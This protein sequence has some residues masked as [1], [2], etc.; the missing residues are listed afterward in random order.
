MHRS[1]LSLS[2]LVHL[3]WT[4][5]MDGMIEAYDAVKGEGCKRV[6]AILDEI[7]TTGFPKL[8][9]YA[10]TVAGR[11]ISLLP[12]VQSLAQIEA[13]YGKYWA[14]VLLD[15]IEQ[16][17]CYRPGS[18]ESAK[19]L[20]EWLGHKSGFA[21]SQNKHES[22]VSE[23]SS[24][25]RIPLMTAHAIKKLG[26]EEVMVFYR[27]L[28]P[29]IVRRLDWRRFPVL[30][31]RHQIPPPLISP[32]PQIEDSLHENAW[33]RPEQLASPYIDPDFIQ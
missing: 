12:V 32:L 1:I 14:D 4:S 10:A 11:D 6:L 22:G 19:R 27:D 31:Q 26:T 5:L 13:H 30:T 25:Q 3:I 17:V 18:Y 33:R 2:P 15:N 7:G 29:A 16:V 20:A 23:G 8:P 9:H 28:D 21:H 24:E